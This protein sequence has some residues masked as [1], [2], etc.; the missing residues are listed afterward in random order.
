MN[1]LE[2][3]KK[4]RDLLKAQF[5]LYKQQVKI[6]VGNEF[7]NIST[8]WAE[9]PDLVL[10]HNIKFKSPNMKQNILQSPIGIEYK[11]DKG[12]NAI[13][14]GVITQ[15][16]QKYLD[17]EYVEKSNNKKFKLNSLA[18]TNTTG[19]NTGYL[20]ERHFKEASN[21][22]IERFCWKGNVAIIKKDQHNGLVF[23]HKNWHFY[24]NGIHYWVEQREGSK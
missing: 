10:F 24:L 20:Y 13:T 23:S 9:K 18:F 5:D 12:L 6:L 21:F 3:Q 1:E 19:I 7:K 14:T 22:F 16:Q 8:H 11:N 17:K 4:F 15:L 2:A